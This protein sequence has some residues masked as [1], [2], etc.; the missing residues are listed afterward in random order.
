MQ[1]SL[2]PS[3]RSASTIDQLQRG[4][5]HEGMALQP[6]SRRGS[7][8][9]ALCTINFHIS[10]RRIETGEVN[11]CGQFR[12]LP[13]NPGSKAATSVVDDPSS[14]VFQYRAVL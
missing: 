6:G 5:S 2:P 4:R 8:P 1:T 12:H 11:K 9:S 10:T 3:P 14:R 13:F 7:D